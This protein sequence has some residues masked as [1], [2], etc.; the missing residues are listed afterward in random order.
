MPVYFNQLIADLFINLWISANCWWK[1][2]VLR[3]NTLWVLI[4]KKNVNLSLVIKFQ[5]H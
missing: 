1:T 4:N 2:P 5:C 3:C